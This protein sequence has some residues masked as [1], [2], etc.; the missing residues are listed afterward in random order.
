[1]TA[2]NAAGCKSSTQQFIMVHPLPIINITR[3][4]TL[5]CVGFPSTLNAS[6]SPQSPAHSYSWTHGGTNNISVV[7]PVTTTVYNVTGTN[8]ITKCVN[9]KTVSVAVFHPVFNTT[10]DTAICIKGSINLTASGAVSYSWGPGGPNNVPF[11]TVSPTVTTIFTVAAT[12]QTVGGL[13][14]ISVRNVSVG[15]YN[16][17]TVTATAD[18][19]VAV[20]RFE[21]IS[22]YGHGAHTYYWS[23]INQT[24]GTVVVTP[25]KETIYTVIGTDIYGC[26]DTT[27]ILVKFSNC[28]GFAE[29]GMTK[30]NIGVYPNPNTGAFV[31]E[32]PVDIEVKLVNGLGQVVREFSLSEHNSRSVSVADLAP[33]VYFITAQQGDKLVN[34]KVI[35]N[36]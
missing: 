7:N 12:S 16:Q 20:C 6:S 10:P 4:P 33:G 9:T 8:N 32:S 11:W 28:P 3:T 29:H 25:T 23:T 5:V 21:S 2:E 34:E 27:S 36:K 14:C 24:A 26:K 22:L 30:M 13:K 15:I 17:P 18:R 1:V 35:I 31:I 19:T